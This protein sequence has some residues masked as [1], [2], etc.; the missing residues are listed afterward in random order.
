MQRDDSA[1]P[2]MLWVQ[3]GEALWQRPAGAAAAYAKAAISDSNGFGAALG[4]MALVD[5]G[6]TSARVRARTP[7]VA[8]AW[9][10]D[11]LRRHL[12]ADERT[13]LRVLR[14]LSRTLSVRLRE[15][16]RRVTR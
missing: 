10:I 13:A 5:E 9:P 7:V 3:E 2:G 16:N 6:P 11:A 4:E 15:T 14:V 8:F 12:A 1:N